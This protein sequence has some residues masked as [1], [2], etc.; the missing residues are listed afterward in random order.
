[1]VHAFTLIGLASPPDLAKLRDTPS[2]HG[3]S[4]DLRTSFV[5]IVG[6]K[7]RYTAVVPTSNDGTPEADGVNVADRSQPVLE[8]VLNSFYPE[9]VQTGRFSKERAV[10]LLSAVTVLSAALIAA[11]A[12]GG[13]NTAS[14]ATKIVAIAAVLAWIV[15]SVMFAWAAMPPKETEYPEIGYDSPDAMI[16]FILNESAATQHE[17]EKRLRRAIGTTI[18]A[19]T[20]S[21]AAFVVHVAIGTEAQ[22]E[23]V[24]VTF[25][26]PQATF[27]QCPEGV[28][29]RTLLDMNTLED[30][31]VA[32]LLDCKDLDFQGYLLTSQ[33]SRVE[34]D[35]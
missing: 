31:M 27:G 11:L 7:S 26:Q 10:H 15:S 18:G 28:P 20:V 6:C 34:V 30:S 35:K 8:A 25:S 23:S 33:L 24:T 17:V 19:L 9:L 13:L 29:G 32:Y 16:T 4:C 21:L 1:M 3:S 12:A 14:T 2:C 5:A 22:W